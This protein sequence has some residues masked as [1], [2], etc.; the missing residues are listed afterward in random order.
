MIKEIN[1]PTIQVG[2]TVRLPKPAKFNYGW[3]K[4]SERLPEK[5]GRYLVVEAHSCKWIGVCSMRDGVF[6]M[7]ITHWQPLPEKPIC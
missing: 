2:D 5:D 7:K 1:D 4:S 3:I 6:D